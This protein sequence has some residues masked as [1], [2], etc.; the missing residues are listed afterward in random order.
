MAD[1]QVI[2]RSLSEHKNELC[3][4]NIKKSLELACNIYDFQETY[5]YSLKSGVSR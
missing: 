1:T 4:E 2:I 3:F 5:A